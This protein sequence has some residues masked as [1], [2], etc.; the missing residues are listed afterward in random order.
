MWVKFWAHRRHYILCMCPANGRRCYNVTSSLIGWTHMLN[1]PC[2]RCLLHVF[3]RKFSISIG[4]FI[5]IMWYEAPAFSVP[6]HVSQGCSIHEYFIRNW[7][8]WWVR[9]SVDRYLGTVLET[10]ST[11][12]LLP[13]SLVI[14]W[15]LYIGKI[16]KSIYNK[17]TVREIYP[18]LFFLIP[19]F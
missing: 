16:F 17:K 4:C 1:D 8:N 19:V 6:L 2:I 12:G 5:T 18:S 3:G 13:G 10:K 15:Y 11:L 14:W 7:H 9:L